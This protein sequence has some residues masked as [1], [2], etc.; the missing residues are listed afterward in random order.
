M[1]IKIKYKYIYMDSGWKSLTKQF[2][3]DNFDRYVGKKILLRWKKQQHPPLFVKN[4]YSTKIIKILPQMPGLGKYSEGDGRS[5]RYT[6]LTSRTFRIMHLNETG[7]NITDENVKEWHISVEINE[8]INNI[9]KTV[10]RKKMEKNE[11][12]LSRQYS[13]L[14]SVNDMARRVLEEKEDKTDEEE[15]YL[16]RIQAQSWPFS[17]SNPRVMPLVMRPRDPNKLP[18]YH[19]NEYGHPPPGSVSGKNSG[20]CKEGQVPCYN[21]ECPRCKRDA[22]I[23]GG[24]KRRTKS[25]FKKKRTK[26]RRKR[27]R[28][29][30]RRK[31][32]RRKKRRRKTRKRR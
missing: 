7:D 23:R 8:D 21:K 10:I 12:H 30:K 5:F 24:K 25:L 28:K 32:K 27:T 6:F 11:D 2:I 15:Y 20:E 3:K 13:P 18:S 17:P 14:P 22:G 1:F 4:F 26:K 16:D 31:T 9:Q 29:K 19:Q